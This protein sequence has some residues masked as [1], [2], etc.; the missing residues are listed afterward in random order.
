LLSVEATL[1]KSEIA[2]SLNRHWWANFLLNQFG[3]FI[4]TLGEWFCNIVAWGF[5]HIQ[6]GLKNNVKYTAR[7]MRFMSLFQ[8]VALNVHHI[9]NNRP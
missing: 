2:A 6:H 4:S 1:A 3:N 5:L 8:W 9:Q 7:F